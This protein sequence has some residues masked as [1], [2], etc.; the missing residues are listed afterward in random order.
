M[1][2]VASVCFSGV[3]NFVSKI[4]SKTNWSIF[5]TSVAHAHY[6][7]LW[8]WLTFAGHYFQRGLLSVSVILVYGVVKSS[9]PGE[10]IEKRDA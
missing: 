3:V 8:K 4:I 2:F 7:L 10:K 5:A 6:I 9:A 1:Y